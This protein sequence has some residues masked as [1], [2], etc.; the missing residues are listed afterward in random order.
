M[1]NKECNIKSQVCSLEGS[2]VIY[3]A[4]PLEHD[5]TSLVIASLILLSET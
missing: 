2:S 3:M 4:T 5:R 1:A